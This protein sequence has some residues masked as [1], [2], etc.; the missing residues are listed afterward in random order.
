VSTVL[1][2]DDSPLVLNAVRDALECDGL[3]V[4]TTDNPLELP[5]LMFRRSPNLVLV[6][7]SMPTMRGD[8]ATRILRRLFGRELVILL[9]TEAN[10]VESV[11]VAKECGANGVIA[12]TD[13]AEALRS[14]VR[15]WLGRAAA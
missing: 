15:S 9:H 6:D 3:H 14:A 8:A 2:V 12:K 13:G 1:V 5:R 4:V 7:L 11:T 10:L